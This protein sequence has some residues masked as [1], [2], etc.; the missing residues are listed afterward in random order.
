MI[1]G[2]AA[3]M[4]PEQARG[5][6]VD[7]RADVWAFGCVLYELLTRTRAFSGRT[8]TDVFAAILE[9]EPDWSRLPSATPAHVTRVLKRTLQKDAAQRLRD[10]GDARIELASG[11]ADEPA[12][13]ARSRVSRPVAVAV[14]AV[15][16]AAALAAV[17]A[18][19]R[20]SNDPTGARCQRPSSG[21]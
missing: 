4:S 12:A 3:Y 6:T 13:P 21:S 17:V 14:G 18:W 19:D 7:K 16:G 10:I 9:R 5:L 2:T 20:T 8:T 15:L 11:A 1:I